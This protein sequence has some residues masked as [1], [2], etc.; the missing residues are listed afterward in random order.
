MRAFQELEAKY[1]RLKSENKE[2]LITLKVKNLTIKD[3]EQTLE[4]VRS[5][6]GIDRNHGE[7][8]AQH[9]YDELINRMEELEDKNRRFQEMQQKIQEIEALSHEK[10]NREEI[11]SK[12]E[13]LK[14]KSIKLYQEKQ[15]LEEDNRVL[16]GVVAKYKKQA[17]EVEKENVLLRSRLENLP[18]QKSSQLMVI[19]SNPA[20][21]SDASDQLQGVVDLITEFRGRRAEEKSEADLEA[22]LHKVK[23]Y[24]LFD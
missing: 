5:S 16:C 14:T 8:L 4:T 13:I 9:N 20:Q 19:Q 17:E 2:L 7:E 24:C 3:L 12:F 23:T 15:A 11:Q 22:L 21:L 18:A 10:D 1:K 6:V